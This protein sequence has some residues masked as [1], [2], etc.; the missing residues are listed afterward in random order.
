MEIKAR[1]NEKT[2]LRSVETVQRKRLRLKI[3][4]NKFGLKLKSQKQSTRLNQ[5]QSNYNLL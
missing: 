1:D 5:I 2:Y 4:E 3:N